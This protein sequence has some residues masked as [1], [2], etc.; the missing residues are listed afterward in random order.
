LQL[1]RKMAP[2][3]SARLK[4]ATSPIA[5]IDNPG[6]W[7]V[8][9]EQL[10]KPPRCLVVRLWEWRLLRLLWFRVLFLRV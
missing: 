3:V 2:L 8:A 1:G 9:S 4:P 6:S 7:I 10:E 5:G